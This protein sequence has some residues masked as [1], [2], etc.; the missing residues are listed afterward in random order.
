MYL[1]L[2]AQQAHSLLDR[3]DRLQAAKKEFKEYAEYNFIHQ[4]IHLLNCFFK[5]NS[6]NSIFNN[7]LLEGSLI[8]LL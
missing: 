4:L 5:I 1:F 2:R 8:I 3:A 6:L 7:V